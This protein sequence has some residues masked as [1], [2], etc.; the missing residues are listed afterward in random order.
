[1]LAVNVRLLLEVVIRPLVV[2]GKSV[3]PFAARKNGHAKKRGRRTSDTRKTTAKKGDRRG[4]PGANEH[5]QRE[6]RGSAQNKKIKPILPLRFNLVQPRDRPNEND[7]AESAENAM[8]AGKVRNPLDAYQSN[9]QAHSRDGGACIFIAG[10]AVG[11][12]KGCRQ[13]GSRPKLYADQRVPASREPAGL[14]GT[15]GAREES[16]SVRRCQKVVLDG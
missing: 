8:L 9:C 16:N 14:S 6:S 11:G 3:V 1:M 2:L 12:N 5:D 15:K 4:A 7:A 10:E 13:I